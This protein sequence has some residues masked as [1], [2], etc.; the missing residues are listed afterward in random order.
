M[1]RCNYYWNHQ[2][3]ISWWTVSRA[4][5]LVVI[6]FKV[7]SSRFLKCN[8]AASHKWATRATLIDFLSHPCIFNSHMTVFFT[9]FFP[10]THLTPMGI[11]IKSCYMTV[12]CIQP[13][14]FINNLLYLYS[15]RTS[16]DNKT[17][18]SSHRILGNFNNLINFD[19][20]ILFC[21]LLTKKHMLIMFI[22]SFTIPPKHEHMVDGVV[23]LLRK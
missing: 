10:K 17:N 15:V 21:K 18:N 4:T 14:F 6:S 7:I 2:V 8:M 1:L 11:C 22:N 12:H 19:I 16:G 23:Q 20:K 3:I 5:L 9:F 13:F